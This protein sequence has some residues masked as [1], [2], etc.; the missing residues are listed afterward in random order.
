MA[1]SYPVPT[2]FSIS[3]DAVTWYRITD[4]NR[5]DIVVNPNP[6][7]KSDRM[8][9]GTMRKY[10]KIVKNTLS[11]SW[12]MIPSRTDETVDGG[13]SSEWMDAFYAANYGI[14]VYVRVHTAGET[15]PTT[16]FYP[17]ELTR[18]SS[19][20]AYTQYKTFITQYS[21]TIVKRTVTRDLA[22]MNIEFTEI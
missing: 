22:N 21:S 1:F 7:E 2:G 5:S 6:I 3:L 18:Q 9:D 11:T 12:S 19:N 4:H 16:G 15:V 20:T 17:N 8:A 10:V 14:P 13:V